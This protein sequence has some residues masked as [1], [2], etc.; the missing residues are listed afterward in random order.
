M[1]PRERRKR[2]QEGKL[3][4]VDLGLG[5]DTERVCSQPSLTFM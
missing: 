3:Q 2:D 5:T 1:Q 4:E